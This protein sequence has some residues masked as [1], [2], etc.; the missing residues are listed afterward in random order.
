MKYSIENKGN[1]K[2]IMYFSLIWKN[3]FG[4]RKIS[5]FSAEMRSRDGKRHR[6]KEENQIE[7]DRQLL[8]HR[9]LLRAPNFNSTRIINV[10]SAAKFAVSGPACWSNF[11]SASILVFVSAYAC[12]TAKKNFFHREN[13]MEKPSEAEAVNN[14]QVIII[15][16]FKYPC[17]TP[18]SF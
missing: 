17:S 9:C 7:K 6:R 16:H 13:K 3:S 1:N 5:L 12:K 2:K 15:F 4:V 18:K 10:M 14:Y 11:V 8:F